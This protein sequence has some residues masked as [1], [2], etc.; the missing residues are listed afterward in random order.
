MAHA[1]SIGIAGLEAPESAMKRRVNTR[2]K[3]D[4]VR[5]TSK[6]FFYNYAAVLSKGRGQKQRILTRNKRMLMSSD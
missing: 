5:I 3:R 1:L 6:S 4:G 2:C